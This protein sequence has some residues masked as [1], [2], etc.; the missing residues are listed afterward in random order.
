[1][2]SLWFL[3]EVSSLLLLSESQHPD[4]CVLNIEIRGVLIRRG[5]GGG[6][7][8]TVEESVIAAVLLSPC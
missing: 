1:M 8:I 7:V 3:R 2:R 5:G 6:C 4:G